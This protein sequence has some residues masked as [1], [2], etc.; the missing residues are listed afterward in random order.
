[1]VPRVVK[2]V[3]NKITI[4]ESSKLMDGNDFDMLRNDRRV[5]PARI[6]N[7]GSLVRE[8]LSLIRA[9]TVT[10][11]SMKCKSTFTGS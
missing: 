7:R 8:S 3:A 5:D 9:D 6:D 10:L 1:M 2:I 11:S 4:A